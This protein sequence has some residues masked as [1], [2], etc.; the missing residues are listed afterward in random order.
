MS[1]TTSNI[2]ITASNKARTALTTVA[3]DFDHISASAKTAETAMS[4]AGQ[5]SG[6]GLG[7]L[8][9][10]LGKVA[11]SAGLGGLGSLLGGAG[12][13]AAVVGV[14]KLALGMADQAT[15]AQRGDQR[16]IASTG[17]AQNANAAVRA[18]TATTGGALGNMT[19]AAA[20]T[21]LFSMGLATNASEAANMAKAALMLGDSS[22]SAKQK[23]DDWSLM[24][25]NQSVERLDQFGISSGKVREEIAKLQAAQPGLSRETAFQTVVMAE[26]AKKMAA[27]AAAGV[28]VGTETD[29]LA[30]Q[31]E[32]LRVTMGKPIAGVVKVVKEGLAGAIGGV[33]AELTGQGP[34]ERAISYY[35]GVKVTA[36]TNLTNAQTAYNKAIEIADTDA[37]SAADA[38]IKFYQAQVDGVDAALKAAVALAAQNGFLTANRTLADAAA[39]AQNR[40]ADAAAGAAQQLALAN[41]VQRP[42]TAPAA[43]RIGTGTD[44]GAQLLAGQKSSE[45]ANKVLAQQADEAGKAEEAAAKKAQSAWQSAFDSLSSQAAGFADTARQATI[46]LTPGGGA[47]EGDWLKPGA[48]GNPFEN[49][50]RAKD[51]AVHGDASQWAKVL[52]MD[53]ATAQKVVAEWEAGVMSAGVQALIDK[54]ALVDR[55]KLKKI[56][57][58][59]QAA[60][61]DE[62]A[63]AA[64]AST[65]SV[66]EL[67]GFTDERVG[68]GASSIGTKMKTALDAQGGTLN[69]AGAGMAGSALA[70]IDSK[71]Q[72]FFDLGWTQAD[73]YMAGYGARL[74]AHS[75]SREMMKLGKA[76]LEGFNIGASGGYGFGPAATGAS[77]GVRG[78]G[79]VAYASSS[80]FIQGDTNLYH[81]TS[82]A[83]LAMAVGLGR[84]AKAKR[85]NG[86]M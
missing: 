5:Q 7:G 64:G 48:A 40:L 14:G 41:A 33:N 4:K 85:L 69:T 23:I 51:V 8:G 43:P 32:N 83:A 81:I 18:M 38:A 54:Q 52:G 78:G 79:T 57:E 2:V 82:P 28:P 17:S 13:A 3:T 25:A 63:T 39:G 61:A 76:A 77:G 80:T 62:I 19:A 44:F 66:D 34:Q 24:M 47:G 29:R 59:T 46:G 20:A 53:Q 12:I 42:N 27:L 26:A 86:G 50:N 49:L 11:G 36:Q 84:A 30:A 6:G 31:W 9:S 73:R 21:R 56:A 15:Q 65:K 68:A 72:S 22:Q 45:D 67:L 10:V 35:L 74:D 16:L 70:G 37:A 60:F 75:P 55:V 71:T 58:T 1:D